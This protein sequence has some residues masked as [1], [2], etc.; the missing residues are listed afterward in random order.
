[1]PVEIVTDTAA[2]A[3]LQPDID[4]LARRPGVLGPF[5]QFGWLYEWWRALGGG[6]ALRIVVVRDGDRVEGVLPLIEE[7]RLGARTLRLLGSAGGGSD[8]LDALAAR[9]VAREALVDAAL[10]LGPDRLELEDVPEASETIALVRARAARRGGRLEIERRYPCPYLGVAGKYP[11]FLANVGRRDNLRRR[12]KWFAAQPG[13]RVRCETDPAA[14]APFLA[15]FFRLHALRWAGDGGSQALQD[16]RLA[17]FHERIAARYAD[18]GRLRLWTMWVAGEAIAVA[19]AFDDRERSIYYQSGML[20]AWGAKSAGLVLFARF[21]ED[22]FTRGLGEVDLLR[23][24]E[25]YKAEWTK[26]RRWTA[27]AR[28]ALTPRGQA[29]AAAERALGRARRLVRSALPEPV[30]VQVAAGVRELRRRS[31]A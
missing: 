23:G 31:T 8:Y 15:R 2:F 26:E 13:Y 21:V 12:E 7:E 10:T 14:V 28:W 9:P 27:A 24:D 1:M 5:N 29:S 4:A 6:R 16:G 11:D 3:R 17:A 22:A 20:P 18:E 30:R 19:Y 25:P